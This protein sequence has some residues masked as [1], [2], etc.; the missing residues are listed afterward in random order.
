[1]TDVFSRVRLG[2]RQKVPLGSGT[3]VTQIRRAGGTNNCN[4]FNTVTRVKVLKVY[5]PVCC[6]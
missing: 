5:L 6:I 1:M 3:S 4:Y 2:R